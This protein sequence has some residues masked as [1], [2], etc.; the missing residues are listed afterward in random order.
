MDP[1]ILK[2]SLVGSHIIK[3]LPSFGK[4]QSPWTQLRPAVLETVPRDEDTG[5][6]GF[7]D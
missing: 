6:R 7:R 3:I 1:N 2:C 4:P 5:V